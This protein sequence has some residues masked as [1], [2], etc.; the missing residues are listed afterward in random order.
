[1]QADRGRPVQ[2]RAQRG[3]QEIA[4]HV[5]AVDDPGRGGVA[6]PAVAVLDQTESVIAVVVVLHRPSDQ[7]LT[8]PCGVHDER[9]GAARPDRV[10]VSVEPAQR[11]R[12]TGRID[13]RRVELRLVD[14]E[15][16]SAG[17]GRMRHRR[18]EKPALLVVSIMEHLDNQ[19]AARLGVGR[20][21]I[22][23]DEVG[24][25]RSRPPR[26]SDRTVQAVMTHL[27]RHSS[28]RRRGG[29]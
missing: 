23:P 10:P 24:A 17:D 12:H 29:S 4:R 20:L 2:V 26:L 19:L 9:C 22:S 13:G 28:Q 14:R 7:S 6:L 3:E 15:R 1:M 18:S 16:I 27:T 21:N 25:D 8:C 5:H 11:G